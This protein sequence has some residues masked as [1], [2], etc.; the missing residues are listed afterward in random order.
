MEEIKDGEKENTAKNKE[1][2]NSHG[3]H[4]RTFQEKSQGGTLE[5]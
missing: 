3:K 1:V 4:P 5:P 2:K